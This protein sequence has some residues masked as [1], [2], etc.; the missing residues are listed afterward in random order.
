MQWFLNRRLSTKLVSAF[1][2]LVALMVAIGV[3]AIAQMVSLR[4]STDELKDN[5]MPSIRLVS[6]IDAGA[7]EYRIEELLH[8]VATDDATK[9]RYEEAMK[10]NEA[11]RA[12]HEAEYVKLI[13]SEE[14]RRLWNDFKAKWQSYLVKHEELI[15]LSRANQTEQAATLMH[16]ESQKLFDESN[17]LLTKLVG[18]NVK[19]GEEAKQHAASTFSTARSTLIAALLVAAAL[20]I[21]MAMALARMVSRPIQE[22]VKVARQV[23]DGDLNTNIQVRSRDESGEL[24]EALQTMT[25]NLTRIVNQV[26]GASD[27]IATGSSQIASGNADLSQRTEEQAANLE[28]TAAS[29]EQ[30]SATVRNNADTAR[31]AAQLAASAATAA[32][33]GGDVVGQV[34]DT[35]E[36]ISTSSRRVVDIIGT[37]DGIAFQTNI[38][39][40]N[41]AVEAARAGEQGRG[42]AVVAGEVRTLAQRSADA[43]K[44]IKSLISASVEKVEAGAHLVT[45]AGSAMNDIVAQ[46]KRVNDLIGEISSATQ[47]QTSGIGQVSDAVAQLDQVTQQNAALVEE[48]AAAAASLSHQ[49]QSLVQA[50]GSFRTHAGAATTPAAH[51]SPP[52]LPPARVAAA[53][54]PVATASP[55][56]LSSSPAAAPAPARATPAPSPIPVAAGNDDWETF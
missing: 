7:G 53:P 46:V 32:A 37:I 54:R 24:L 8:V 5:W 45:E 50:V 49:A 23:A 38:L 21:G 18:L 29:M 47:E 56:T 9:A 52:S 48:S 15:K 55:S 3:F 1:S 30:L 26:R 22:A 2:A 11:T 35:M 17:G 33:H 20:G 34:V 14:E 43:A 31:M 41:A 36:A 19:G 13:S 4:D 40:L 44:E 6:T 12:G 42:F 28:E 27:S 51:R 16:G 39:A 10:R 25:A